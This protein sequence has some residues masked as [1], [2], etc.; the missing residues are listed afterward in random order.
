MTEIGKGWE[1]RAAK[2]A[3]ITLYQERQ[4]IEMLARIKQKA[5]R[6]GFKRVLSLKETVNSDSLG[7]LCSANGS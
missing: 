2:P 3:N 7:H 1:Q 4:V 5:C 6:V